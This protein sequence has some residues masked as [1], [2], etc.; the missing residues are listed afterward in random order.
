M[1]QSPKERFR[2]SKEIAAQHHERVVEK[3]FL[4][5]CDM[6]LLQMVQNVTRLSADAQSA[7]AGYFQIAGAVEYR[8]TLLNLAESGVE[9]PR[10][11]DFNLN[12]KANKQ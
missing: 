4:L 1:I 10:T 9:A 7:L 6:A 2:E 5:A 3:G 11:K 8:N 12:F